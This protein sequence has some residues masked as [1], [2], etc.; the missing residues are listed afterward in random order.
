MLTAAKILF[1]RTRSSF[2]RT[3]AWLWLCAC[4]CVVY[5]HRSL[6]PPTAAAAGGGDAAADRLAIFTRYDLLARVVKAES[7]EKK[8][9]NKEKREKTK[10]EKR[11]K[12]RRR[13]KAATLQP[14]SVLPIPLSMMSRASDPTTIK[15]KRDSSSFSFSL[16]F[17][18]F[19]TE[20]QETRLR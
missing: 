16:S 5:V 19:K 20:A 4:C 17:M 15:D 1:R 14:S 11:K 3:G 10:S 2:R 7:K 8:G 9:V 13:R 18:P 6:P 12:R